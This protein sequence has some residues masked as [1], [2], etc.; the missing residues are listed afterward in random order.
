MLSL[1]TRVLLM[2][3]A[4]GTQNSTVVRAVV[5]SRVYVTSPALRYRCIRCCAREP[6]SA[7]ACGRSGCCEHVS[8]LDAETG[9]LYAEY[10]HILLPLHVGDPASFA[11]PHYARMVASMV[12]QVYTQ[13]R[14]M[15]TQVFCGEHDVGA[16]FSS[17]TSV[18]HRKLLRERVIRAP[19]PRLFRDSDISQNNPPSDARMYRAK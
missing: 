16:I 18:S 10:A 19:L 11:P 7:T 15:Q 12:S 8:G 5:W 9:T 13:L 14:H 3:S 4:A 6:S 1:R 2:L 17:L